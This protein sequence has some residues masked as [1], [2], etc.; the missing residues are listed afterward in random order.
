MK[1][2]RYYLTLVVNLQHNTD[3]CVGQDWE[4]GDAVSQRSRL[5]KWKGSLW[6]HFIS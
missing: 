3:V 6:F 4:D 5:C 1:R 2:L